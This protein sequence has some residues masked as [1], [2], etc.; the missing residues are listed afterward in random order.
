MKRLRIFLCAVLALV[1]TTTY[2]QGAMTDEERITDLIKR[3]ALLTDVADDCGEQ[4]NYY[5]KK[6]LTGELCTRFKKSFYGQWPSREALQEEI[7]GYTI[8]LSD[9]L[10]CERC[11]VIL[12]RA[13][14]LRITVVYYLDYMDYMEEL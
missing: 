12:A 8:R 11:Q 10:K 4:M 5:G 13:E 7:T 1:S 2:S 3:L 6:A 9:Q 14:E